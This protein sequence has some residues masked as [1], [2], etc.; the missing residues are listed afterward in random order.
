MRRDGI[1]HPRLAELLAA[2]GHYDSIVLADAGLPVPRG[3]ETIDLVWG[4]G[5]PALLPVLR[6]VAGELVVQEAVVAHELTDAAFLA[7]LRE[8]V[9]G[10]PVAAVDH[11]ELKALCGRAHAVVRTGEA[12]PYAN[13]ILRAGV[14]F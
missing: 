13:V 8:A 12:T 14:A 3:V 6:A 9:G 11:E 10:V 5:E 1:W 7:G 4:R 2:L